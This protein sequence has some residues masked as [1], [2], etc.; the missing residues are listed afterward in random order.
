MAFAP[1]SLNASTFVRLDAQEGDIAGALPVP[2]VA[3]NAPLRLCDTALGTGPDNG[4]PVLADSDQACVAAQQCYDTSCG[5]Y[6]N[7]TSPATY[8]WCITSEC[9]GALVACRSRSC[10]SWTD[11]VLLQHGVRLGGIS[12]A[13]A[14]GAGVDPAVQAA[15]ETY[16]AASDTRG[17]A[18]AQVSL[19]F[20]YPSPP[21]GAAC[22]GADARIAQLVT[23]LNTG[24][25]VSNV[26]WGI[27]ACG[28]SGD[29]EPMRMPGQP[30]ASTAT[31]LLS[32][33]QQSVCT[34][35]VQTNGS[36][37]AGA[38]GGSTGGSWLHFGVFS[39]VLLVAGFILCCYLPTRSK[40]GQQPDMQTVPA[41]VNVVSV[42]AD[43]SLAALTGKDTGVDAALAAQS[44]A[45][46]HSQPSPIAH[47]QVV[48]AP[49][50][51]LHHPTRETGAAVDEDVIQVSAP[52]EDDH[53]HLL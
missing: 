7:S 9:A 1:G 13:S 52:H 31:C 50:S 38:E 44:A 42:A 17:T 36:W 12:S 43:G 6:K 15:F 23:P 2:W 19:G 48:A 8:A 16:R 39:T 46:P 41:M 27:A 47:E 45:M 32:Q 4:C 21:L 25:V 53:I 18:A 35:S 3:S 34:E 5:G 40:R 26:P 10:I 14:S 22:S 24:W 37:T 49:A 33:C 28:P 51:L 20:C 29:V 30:C 11:P